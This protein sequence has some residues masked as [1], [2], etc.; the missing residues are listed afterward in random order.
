MSLLQHLPMVGKGNSE[1][2]FS[3]DFKEK[4]EGLEALVELAVSGKGE[5]SLGEAR[6]ALPLS[7]VSV[8]YEISGAGYEL[9]ATI[10]G[11]RNGELP[12]ANDVE[13]AGFTVSVLDK[14][15]WRAPIQAAVNAYDGLKGG[16]RT[17]NAI[18]RFRGG[19]NN[20]ITLY[21]QKGNLMLGFRQD[22][23]SG[24]TRQDI[25]GSISKFA[26]ALEAVINSI[27]DAGGQQKSTLTISPTLIERIPPKPIDLSGY[28]PKPVTPAG[29]WKGA[30][31]PDYE[32]K[33]NLNAVTSEVKFADIGGYTFV[34][35][36]LAAFIKHI[37]NPSWAKQNGFEYPKL[38]ILYGPP[39]TGKTL[40]GK[41]VAGESGAVFIEANAADFL[42]PYVGQSTMALEELIT[43]ANAEAQKAVKPAVVFI[44]EI[45]SLLPERGSQH[46]VNDEL[47]NLLNTY[48]QGMR[49][50]Q[51]PN[52]Y[53]MGATNRYGAMDKSAVRAG[54]AIALEVGMPDHEARQRI[55]EAT[56]AT[57]ERTAGRE[58]FDRGISYASLAEMTGGFS[59]ADIAAV[60]NQTRKE[61]WI[62]TEPGASVTKT[63]MAGLE[64]A[65]AQ[66][67]SNTHP[68]PIGFGR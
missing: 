7:S 47:V 61:S 50:S 46:H 23:T 36:E 68:K 34:K 42:R 33:V 44:D 63:T 52:L 40:F 38:V 35:T 49:S 10:A 65:I 30:A 53:F 25:A 29:R 5:Y 37:Q 1:P 4:M 64:K 66:Y 18:I 58:L 8:K 55:F 27:Y 11:S 6:L 21:N 28:V 57:I 2:G 24:L 12:K 13:N 45:D 54:R 67:K 51:I 56:Q 19:G 14:G 20:R 26:R 16:R 62:Q 59:G 41:A 48:T 31:P 3:V 32:L 39:G 17:G 9:E 15:L 60:M 43:K 22:S